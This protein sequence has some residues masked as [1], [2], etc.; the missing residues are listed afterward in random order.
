MATNTKTKENTE[1]GPELQELLGESMY[2][3]VYKPNPYGRFQIDVILKDADQLKKAESLGMTIKDDK[4]DGQSYVTLTRNAKDSNGETIDS[5]PVTDTNGKPVEE[6]VGNGSKVV[7]QFKL[8]PYD[9]KYGKGLAARF[10]EV[11]VIDL[12]PYE[13]SK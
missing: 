9:N 3:Q 8:F 6:L 7:V 1:D 10:F 11:K 2:A 5:I 12:V 4:Y 13:A